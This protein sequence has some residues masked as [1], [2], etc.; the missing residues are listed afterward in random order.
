MMTLN[1]MVREYIT[2]RAERLALEKKA[3]DIKDG[4]EA[5]LRNSILMELA[6]QGMK[7][8]HLEGV[9]R[10]TSK[11]STHYEIVDLELLAQVMFK[12][13][14]DNLKEG[15]SLSDALMLQSRPSREALETFMEDA[16]GI[17]E[18][19]MQ[20]LGVKLV[21]RPDLSVTKA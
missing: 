19:A 1:D 7:S 3:K 20:A 4:R 8:A 11:A 2:L 12:R 21:E 18:Q 9:A 5:E 13:M 17:T 10:V 6:A 14:I 16:G 15:R